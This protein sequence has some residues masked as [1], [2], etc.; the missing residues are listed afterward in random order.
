MLSFAENVET[1]HAT[2]VMVKWMGKNVTLAHLHMNYISQERRKQMSALPKSYVEQIKKT[3]AP[4]DRQIMLC[5]NEEEI[6]MLGTIMLTKAKCI[7]KAQL[8]KDATADILNSLAAKT[9]EE[10]DVN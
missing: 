6:M 7:L 5:D 4:L 9:R 1:T 2:V 10:Q 8:G 3:M